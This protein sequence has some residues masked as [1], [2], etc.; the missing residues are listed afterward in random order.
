[1][2]AAYFFKPGQFAHPIFILFIQRLPVNLWIPQLFGT[3]IRVLLSLIHATL[4]I[5]QKRKTYVFN[6]SFIRNRMAFS[7]HVESISIVFVDRSIYFNTPTV[8]SGWRRIV[9]ILSPSCNRFKTRETLTRNK[10]S[11]QVCYILDV[12][13]FQVERLRPNSWEA[14]NALSTFVV[15]L[16]WGIYFY[17][18]GGPLS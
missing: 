16:Y 6:V 12:L 9:F 4:L 3:L 14:T 7:F 13:E 18:K 1:M 2:Q 8:V 15:D 10:N 5:R 17:F 11:V